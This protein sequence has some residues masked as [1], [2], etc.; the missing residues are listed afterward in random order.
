MNDFNLKQAIADEAEEI[1]KQR[2]NGDF[3]DFELQSAYRKIQNTQEFQNFKEL[4]IEKYKKEIAHNILAKLEG[5]D[6]LIKEAGEE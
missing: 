2:Y 4:C 1:F 6:N 3:E 5:L